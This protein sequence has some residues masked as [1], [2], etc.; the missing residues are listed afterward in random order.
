M[1]IVLRDLVGN[2]C[3]VFIDDV[4]VFGKTIK[5]H[6]S[7][8]E[9]VLQRFDRSNLQLQPSKCVFAKPRVEYLGYIVSRN[10]I[11]ASPDK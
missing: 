10:G 2:E 7:R 1:D 5:E 6:T 3:N 11:K 9:R 4:I 8:L